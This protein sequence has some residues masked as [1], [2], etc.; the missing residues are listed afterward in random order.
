MEIKNI[1]DNI[2]VVNGIHV[3]SHG[4]TTL[5]SAIQCCENSHVEKLKKL[6]EMTDQVPIVQVETWSHLDNVTRRYYFFENCTLEKRVSSIGYNVIDIFGIE[7]IVLAFQKSNELDLL[8]ID[9]SYL[10][11]RN[12]VDLSFLQRKFSLMYA[13]GEQLP[14]GVEVKHVEHVLNDLNQYDPTF[15]YKRLL[16]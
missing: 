1:S 11:Q 8:E 16:V 10:D 9:A 3:L 4:K 12:G 5:H 6:H 15:Y 13:K 2:I 14:E 7:H